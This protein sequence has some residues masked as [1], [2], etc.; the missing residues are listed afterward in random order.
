MLALRLVPPLLMARAPLM[1]LNGVE[2]KP[3]AS[4]ADLMAKSRVM[5]RDC[6]VLFI[7]AVISSS[8]STIVSGS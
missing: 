8:S 2:T 4:D 3:A 5:D 7:M 6:M 1:L